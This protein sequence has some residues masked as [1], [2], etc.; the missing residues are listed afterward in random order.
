[1]A[2]GQTSQSHKERIKIELS[3]AGVSSYGLLKME[4]RYLHE[5]IG[6]KEHVMAAAYGLS[7]T[8]SGMLVATDKRIIYTER[9]P[10]YKV[11]DEVSYSMVSGIRYN[12]RGNRASVIL[13]TRIGDYGLRFV[14]KKAAEKFVSYIEAVRLQ[15]SSSE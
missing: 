1:M 8:F 10:F 2:D 12:L 5:I 3:H 13:H 7:N 14:N 9:K 11:V 6:E 15:N 4:A